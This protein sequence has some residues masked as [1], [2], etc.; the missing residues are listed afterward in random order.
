[1]TADVGKGA[2]VTV[3]ILGKEYRLRA[4]GDPDHV[5]NVAAHVDRVLRE[6]QRTTPDT[7]DAAILSALN[8]ASELLQLRGAVEVA[9]RDRLQALIDLV[10]SA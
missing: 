5:Q 8:I 7:V 4:E 3:K 10:D 1:M 6:V 2:A 9:P